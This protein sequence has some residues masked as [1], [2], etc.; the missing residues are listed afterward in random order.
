MTFFLRGHPFSTDAYA[1]KK[2][3]TPIPTKTLLDLAAQIL[4]I[5]RQSSLKT[6][7]TTLQPSYDVMWTE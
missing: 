3:H 2:F 4:N 7:E 6:I 1:S 5:K